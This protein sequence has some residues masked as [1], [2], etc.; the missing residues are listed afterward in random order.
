VL[1][2]QEKEK[3]TREKDKKCLICEKLCYGKVCRNCLKKNKYRG[4]TRRER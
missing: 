2:N 4:L 1:G 3:M